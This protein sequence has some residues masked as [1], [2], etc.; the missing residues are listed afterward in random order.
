[1]ARYF[2][3]SVLKCLIKNLGHIHGSFYKEGSILPW[4]DMGR[5][6]IGEPKDVNLW[7]WKNNASPQTLHCSVETKHSTVHVFPFPQLLLVF[8]LDEV[9]LNKFFIPK[10]VCS[11]IT[12]FFHIIHT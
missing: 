1:M 12:N 10:S 9:C 2:I 6:L 8:I 5:E 7:P 11:K 3:L 4:G